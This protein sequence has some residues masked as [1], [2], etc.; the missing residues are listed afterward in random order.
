MCFLVVLGV[1]DL[2]K[3]YCVRDFRKKREREKKL[4]S[5]GDQKMTVTIPRG[6]LS[7]PRGFDSFEQSAH[8]SSSAS[9]VRP[10]PKKSMVLTAKLSR[11]SQNHQKLSKH[12]QRTPKNLH[13]TSCIYLQ[14]S[15]RPSKNK[16]YHDDE[17]WPRTAD[18]R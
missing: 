4:I 10:L 6:F 14:L 18:E 1:V 17:R 2:I 5:D 3:Y 13:R 7:K 15:Q 9:V 8:R 16:D 12:Q 11:S